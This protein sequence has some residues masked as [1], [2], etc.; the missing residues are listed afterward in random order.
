M[1]YLCRK[2]NRRRLEWVSG[3]QGELHEKFPFLEVKICQSDE[4]F[5]EKCRVA[6][7]LLL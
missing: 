1:V 6:S 3:G 2:G 7:L 5:A 4:L